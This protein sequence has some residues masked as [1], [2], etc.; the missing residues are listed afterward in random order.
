MSFTSID[1]RMQCFIVFVLTNPVVFKHNNYISDVYT[2]PQIKCLDSNGLPVFA[3]NLQC[4]Y[5]LFS[6]NQPV[7]CMQIVSTFIQTLTG[8]RTC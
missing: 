7:A 1:T 6:I 2:N 5:F 4:Q 8:S 3:E